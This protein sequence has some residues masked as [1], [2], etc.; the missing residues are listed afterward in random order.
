MEDCHKATLLIASVRVARKRCRTPGTLIDLRQRRREGAL[1]IWLEPD[2]PRVL[3]A[4]QVRGERPWV[5]Q[6]WR[7][8]LT[9]RP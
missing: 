5:A 1:A 8:R 3:S 2:G 7:K 6:Y 9:R 4:R